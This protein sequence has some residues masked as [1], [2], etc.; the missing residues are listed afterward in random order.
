M[1]FIELD[2]LAVN[3]VKEFLTQEKIPPRILCKNAKKD[4]V[5]K[6]KNFEVNRERLFFHKDGKG[7]LTRF[8]ANEELRSKMMAIK[9]FHEIG[10]NVRDK[11]L[12]ALKTRIYGVTREECNAVIRSCPACQ[13]KRLMTTKPVITP[14]I[15]K[16]P[17]DRYLADLI[18]F[19]LYK[20][21]NNG[22]GWLL[23][24]ID[25]YSKYVYAVPCY[26]KCMQE[27]S[28]HFLKA[29]R[30]FGPPVILHT[31][32]GKEFCN[33]EVQNICEEFNIKMIHGRAR[34]PWFKAK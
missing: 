25:S 2:I 30:L 27:V 11:M 19:R 26:R 16:K 8:F 9:D 29:F 5:K 32:N 12:P 15:A 7:G 4:F 34:C 1:E 18:D 17:R 24:I 3:E 14:I 10:H 33:S 22:Y 31:D 23:I 20:S 13:V 21:V 28:K 6:C